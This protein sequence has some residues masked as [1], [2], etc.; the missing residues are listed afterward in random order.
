MQLSSNAI[1]SQAMEPTG[2]RGHIHSPWSSLR[3]AAVLVK[4]L[5]LQTIQIDTGKSG[6]DFVT[7]SNQTPEKVSARIQ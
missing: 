1:V 4:Q 7:L 3:V 5:A 2:H 6:R